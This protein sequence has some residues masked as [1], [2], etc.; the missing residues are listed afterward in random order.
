MALTA[1]IPPAR[2]PPA[3]LLA[4]LLLAA[5]TP[6]SAQDGPGPDPSQARVLVHVLDYVAQDY[7]VA[8]ADGEVVNAAEYAEMEEFGW[9]AASL[10]DELVAAGV[11]PASDGLARS[12]D[13]LRGSI[14]DKADPGVVARRAR[15]L[16]DRV[17]ARSGLRT[18][19]ARWPDVARGQATFAQLC[20]A[21]HG[22]SGGGD[23]PL[24]ADLD[25]R[26]SNLARG[27][28]AASLSPFQVYNTVRLGVE[29]T[30]M[31]A[32]EELTDEEVWEV[33]FFVKSLGA[34][35]AG[36]GADAARDAPDG[37]ASLR[38]VATLGDRDLA[39]T[40]A[41]RG[42]GAP[43]RAVAALRTGGPERGP[44]GTLGLARRHLGE[45]L[46]SYRRGEAGQARQSALL[47]YLDGVEPAEPTLN[48][49]DPALTV[50]LEERMLAVRSAIEEGRSAETVAGAVAQAR[51]SIAEAERVVGRGGGSPWFSFFVAASILLREGLE[52]FLV[53]LAILGVLRSLGRP[54]AARWVH[55]GWALAVA[56]GAA[57]WL[58]SDWV[59][60][61]GAVQRE[62]ME[63]AIALFAVGVLLY[64]GFW[65]HSMT[66]IGRWKAFVHER[67]GRVLSS[68][69]LVGL[70]AISFF[71]VFREAFE[72]VLFLSALT[73]EQGPDHK[74]AVAGGAVVAVALVIALAAV[75]LRYSVRLPVQKLFRYSS[76]VMGAL[77][78]VLVGKGVHAFQEAGVLPVTAVPLP[79]R[80]DLL[81]VYP[82]AETL[83]AQAVLLL[84][85]VLV[86]LVRERL[87]SAAAPAGAGSHG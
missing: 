79:V 31:P 22:T 64:V 42:V 61:L 83:G 17:V 74:A 73:L 35:Q 53:I 5:L 19:P 25:P 28:R 66:E 39:D 85:V 46:A 37:V 18:A 87:P 81:G 72:S 24:A 8:V 71:A 80:L 86:Y 4:A 30:A 41:S 14:A 51:A 2:I 13:R 1:R 82:T 60:R 27:E 50:A 45:A 58:L 84:A 77:C 59:L 56:V 49:R 48:A 44:A 10:V 11:L 33:A 7:T 55:A 65:L 69:N 32:F 38:E 78:V 34:A 57:A 20:T 67:V 29:G 76:F 16:R 26:P 70:A 3:L 23:G 63:G 12:A 9:H 62:V 21:C 6:A 43:A 68:G 75:L 15:G 36:D 40:L 52:A 54:E 47:A